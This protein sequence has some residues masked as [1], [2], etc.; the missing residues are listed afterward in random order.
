MIKMKFWDKE[1]DLY[2]PAGG[3]MTPADIFERYGWAENPN[4]KVVIE[5]TGGIWSSIASLEVLKNMY[6]VD[7]ED[8]YEAL[9]AIENIMNTPPEP[10]IPPEYSGGQ[11]DDFIEGVLEALE[12]VA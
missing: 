1:T 12:E 10:Y 2:P 4:T 5:E 6:N 7:I 11:Y 8:D 3:K 9:Q